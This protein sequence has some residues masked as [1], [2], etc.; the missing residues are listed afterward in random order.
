MVRGGKQPVGCGA[1]QAPA[2]KVRDVQGGGLERTRRRWRDIQLRAE[3]VAAEGEHEHPEISG[4]EDWPGGD[5][6]DDETEE[7]ATTDGPAAAG[8]GA[9]QPA[10]EADGS[11]T[12]ARAA[13]QGETGGEVAGVERRATAEDVHMSEAGAS[14]DTGHATPEG[15]RADAAATSTR[16]SDTL[17][18][19]S[20]ANTA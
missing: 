2:G 11:D 18:M 10:E 16:A 5:E 8:G 13:A 4:D 20:V 6:T 17:H 12:P 7:P 15:A 9:Q 19:H 1:Q 14:G 3:L